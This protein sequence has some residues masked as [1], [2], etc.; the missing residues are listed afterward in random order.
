M[1]KPVMKKEGQM[2][3]ELKIDAQ[4]RDDSRFLVEMWDRSAWK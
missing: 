4:K 3:E 2:E 1:L